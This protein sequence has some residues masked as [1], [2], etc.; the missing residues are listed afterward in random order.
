[1][2]LSTGPIYSYSAAEEPADFKAT[3]L[4]LFTKNPVLGVDDT[5]EAGSADIR[6]IWLELRH[7]VAEVHGKPKGR[8]RGATV[9]GEV[10]SKILPRNLSRFI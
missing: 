8:R 4:R 7:L 10:R 1:M 5:F 3:K 6:Q 2:E 9:H